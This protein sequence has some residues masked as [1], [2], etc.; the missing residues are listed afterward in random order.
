MLGYSCGDDGTGSG[1]NTTNP[2]DNPPNG[3]GGNTSNNTS[4]TNT[5]D[6]N[7]TT[8]NV[9]TIAEKIENCL[10]GISSSGNTNTPLITPGTIDA[11]N[12]GKALL[13][14]MYNYLTQNNCSEDAQEF[15]LLAIEADENDIV[16]YDLEMI[17][18]ITETIEFQNQTC[19]KSIKDDVV[20]TGQMSKIIKK[21]EPTYPVLHLEW[22]MFSNS[23]WGNTGNTS[24]NLEQDTA[25]INLNSQSLLH[26]SNIVMVKTIAHELIHAE[27]YR[28]LKE[29]VDDYNIISLAEYNALQDNF[30]GIADYTL[31]YGSLEYSQD[32][33]GNFITWGLI[34]DFSLAHH[35]QMAAFYRETIIKVMK[36]YDLSK[37]VTRPNAD[38]F[39][40]ALSWAGL[41][42]TSD[43]N[44]E[45]SQYIDAWKNFINQV[46]I[47]EVDVAVSERTYNRY[48]N[49]IDQEYNNTGIN[50]N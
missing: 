46:D 4:E 26:V 22:G 45:N 40:E 27:L 10:N 29:L 12:L 44:G 3:G 33:M 49:I 30:M 9:F 28:K 1:G 23:E 34:P 19:L 31:R 18:E 39:Y 2:E 5:T 21:F 38:E 36:A 35:N 16:D 13:N 50:C 20:S 7:I 43:E 11:L 48:I 42:I 37:G 17:V 41:R 8:L 14:E 32:I 25:F 6:T 15:V 47:D 24:L